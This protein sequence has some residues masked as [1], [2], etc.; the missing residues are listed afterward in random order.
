MRIGVIF[1]I[2]LAAL[3]AGVVSFD[4]YRA[5]LGETAYGAPFELVDQT[6]RPVTQSAFTGHPTAVFFG[7][8]HCPDV[9]PTT[10][11]E[12]DDWLAQL[13]TT[14][15]AIHAYF[16]TVDPER[17]TPPELATYI[18]NV[19]S[20]ITGI[21]GDP[22]KVRAMAKAYGIYFRRIDGEDGDYSME[23]TASILLLD[24]R[25]HLAGTIAFGEDRDQ[26]LSKLR[27]LAEASDGGAAS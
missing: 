19:S 16:V 18:G 20:R 9:C 15:K 1:A 4:W 7:Y 14:G 10:L 25:G 21:S 23:H 13:G 3:G 27:R 11:V 5:T 12:L 26:A 6:G 2:A 17:D 22:D 8:T 24:E